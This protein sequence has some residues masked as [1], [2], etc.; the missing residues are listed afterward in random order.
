LFPDVRRLLEIQTV[1]QEIARL[2]RALDSVP[3]E[4]SKREKELAVLRER[5]RTA[6]QALQDA[7]VAARANDTGIRECDN[8]IKKLEERLNAVKNN[9]EYQA[10]LL[11][12]ESVRTDRNRLE[13]EGLALIDNI[14]TL[15]AE[16][17]AAG[18]ARREAETVF[19]EFVEKAEALQ[20][21]RR[22]ELDRVRAGRDA[23]LAEVPA[24]LMAKY[25]RLFDARD[26][27]AVCAVEGM[28]CTGCYTSI[29]PNLFVKLHGGSSVVQCSSCQRILYLPE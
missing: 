20:A 1:D 29:Q 14:E 7:E 28:T 6:E 17:E 13:E 8:E 4:R 10:T 19:A 18:S 21:D 27:L 5:H 25:E 11:Q 3:A 26:N 16:V 2:G 15:K 23:L 22:G 24:E 12:I 9:A